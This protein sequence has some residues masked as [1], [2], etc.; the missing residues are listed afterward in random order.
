MIRSFWGCLMILNKSDRICRISN[1]Y[2]AIILSKTISDNIRR[3]CFF[4]CLKNKS[5]EFVGFQTFM[6]LLIILSEINS[7]ED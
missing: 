3:F 7:D 5:F 2:G 6:A 1:F 4:E